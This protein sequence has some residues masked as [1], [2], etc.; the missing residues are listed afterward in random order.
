MEVPSDNILGWSYSKEIEGLVSI[1]IDSVFY[2]NNISQI[3]VDRN[4]KV[5][6]KIKYG[7]RIIFKGGYF[8]I[9]QSELRTPRIPKLF[10]H[11]DLSVDWGAPILVFHDF[12]NK[13]RTSKV[14]T[15]KLGEIH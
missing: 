13:L 4:S 15:K 10:V 14:L 11:D 12:K 2:R 7:R 8:K 5:V 9:G 6:Y 3:H 1:E